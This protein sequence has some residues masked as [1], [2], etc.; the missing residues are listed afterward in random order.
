MGSFVPF[1]FRAWVKRL[2][3]KSGTLQPDEA[4]IDGDSAHI[5]VDRG[6]YEYQAAPCRLYGINTPEMTDKDPVVRSKAVAAR[7]FLRGLILGREVFVQSMMLDKYGR[8][9]VIVWTDVAQFGD[10]SKSVNRAMIDAG[11]SVAYL[12]DHGPL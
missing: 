2:D 1:S 7:D 5:F 12:Q 11:H 3:W 8:P 4:V 9:I 6:M 10:R